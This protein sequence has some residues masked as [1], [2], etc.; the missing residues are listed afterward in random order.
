MTS[1]WMRPVTLAEAQGPGRV[2]DGIFLNN[3]II[4]FFTTIYLT[5]LML[6]AKF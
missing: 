5:K 2:A 4:I 1:Q 6:F 3:R